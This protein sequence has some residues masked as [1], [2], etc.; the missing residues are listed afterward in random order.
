MLAEVAELPQGRKR[1]SRLR[2][3]EAQVMAT[4][5]VIPLWHDE[6]LHLVSSDWVGWQVSAINRLDL[7]HVH[8]RDARP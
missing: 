6:V 7:R 5:P 4:V 8:R 1:E 3:L 2:D